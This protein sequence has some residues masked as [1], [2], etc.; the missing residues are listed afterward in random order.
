MTALL[1]LSL[2]TDHGWSQGNGDEYDQDF[3]LDVVVKSLTE[4]ASGHPLAG[5]LSEDELIFTLLKELDEELVAEIQK[6]TEETLVY[7]LWDITQTLIAIFGDLLEEIKVSPATP[8]HFVTDVSQ[9]QDQSAK[10]EASLVE[11]STLSIRER[12]SPSTVAQQASSSERQDPLDHSHSPRASTTSAANSEHTSENPQHSELGNSQPSSTTSFASELSDISTPS[13][14][15]HT[16]TPAPEYDEDFLLDLVVNNLLEKAE[17]HPQSHLYTL[18]ELILLLLKDLHEELVT[19]INAGRG[20]ALLHQLLGIT[21]ELIETFEAIA[22]A[23]LVPIESPSSDSMTPTHSSRVSTSLHSE[24]D[25]SLHVSPSSVVT[26]EDVSPTENTHLLSPTESPSQRESVSPTSNFRTESVEPQSSEINAIATASLSGDS[27]TPSYSS[28]ISSLLASKSSKFDQSQNVSP[29]SVINSEDVPSEESTLLF[30]TELP[31]QG[32][33][34]TTALHLNTESVGQVNSKTSSVATEQSISTIPSST[35][36]R[37]STSLDRDSS[38]LDQSQSVSATSASNNVVNNEDVPP[39]VN[40][41]LLFPTELPSQEKSLATTSSFVIESVAPTS[42]EINSIATASLS[43]DSRTPSS[44]SR[45]S[46]KLDSESSKFD[47]NVSPS[48][49]I[50]SEDVPSV[51]TLPLFSTKV[52]SQGMSAI[53]PSILTTKPL[54][55]PSNE[56]SPTPNQMSS[57]APSSP[58]AQDD[59]YDEDFLLDLV[60]QILT[61]KASVH[62]LAGVLSEDE[63]ILTLLKELD[64]ELVAEIQKGTDDPLVYQL[65]DITQT[66]IAIFDGLVEETPAPVHSDMTST[67]SSPEPPLSQ[68]ESRNTEDSTSINYS[69]E[70]S[71]SQSKRTMNT[72]SST[73]SSQTKESRSVSFITA[74]ESPVAMSELVA[75]SPSTVAEEL[76]STGEHT[77]EYPQH[78]ELQNS[79]P[80]SRAS[81]A[82]ALPEMS[83]PSP[84]SHTTTPPPVYDEDFL[85]DLII[86][87]L[88]E[89]AENHPH[90]DLYTLDELIL[91]LLKDLHEELVAEIDA[92]RGDALV[93]Q[94]L[95]ITEE[96]IETFEALVA[97]PLVVTSPLIT[98]SLA[99]RQSSTSLGESSNSDHRQSLSPSSLTSNQIMQS[100]I[101]PSQLKTESSAQSSNQISTTPRSSHFSLS[102]PSSL[103]MDA[104]FVSEALGSGSVLDSSWVVAMPTSSGLSSVGS[105]IPSTEPSRTL[106]PSASDSRGESFSL[107][108]RRC[109]RLR[110]FF[111]TQQGQRHRVYH[112]S[113]LRFL[114]S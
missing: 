18:D 97:A 92:G 29:S 60:I 95:A 31:S 38:K 32:M 63:L 59:E 28:R 45:M 37:I 70:P 8:L 79:P 102:T 98:D 91:L 104:S 50:N 69:P 52:P 82:S 14:T 94:L 89:K 21:E 68:S 111:G 1:V 36:S 42:S 81:F 99:P 48:P 76:D 113:W 114:D 84:T 110:I 58:E 65:L 43:T 10:P 100:V 3:L 57:S 7:Q 112:L 26:D 44:S 51:S 62:P 77:S 39:T 27:K 22:A 4:K 101:S 41:H 71:Q 16:S 105:D 25:Q 35:S 23:N 11:E 103:D 86:N 24:S 87:N 47:Q 30:S 80:S 12:I 54:P 106:T 109:S 6:G 5:V 90:S 78:S 56:V 107:S 93:H 34:L 64:T 66:L 2:T 75:F 96:L 49:V 9:T 83:T 85:L 67:I 13:P 72:E 15:S 19:E 33:S 55:Q 53:S 61:E 46:T 88:L 74:D 108:S 40:T 17:N 73:E 20:D